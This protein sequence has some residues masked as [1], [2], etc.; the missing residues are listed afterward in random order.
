M[1]NEPVGGVVEADDVEP[2]VH[3]HTHTE[4]SL[5][6]G[7][8]RITDLVAA[9][10][11]HGQT[12]LAITDH[13]ALYG[14][15]KFYTAARSAGIKPIIGCEMYMAPR[16]R[17]DREGRT[18]RDPNH[19]I[20]LARNET[21]YR[22]L[23][24]LVSKSHLEGYYYKPRIDKELLAEHADGLICLSACIGGELPQAILGGDMDAAESVARQHME[25][26]GPDGYFLEMMDHA[27]AEE[28]A[29]RAGLLEIARRTG[30]PLVATNDAHYIGVEDA[31]AHDILLCIQTQARREDEKRFRFA[32]PH[33]SVTSGAHMRDRFAAYGEA[34]RNTVAV[35]GLCNLELKLG[36]NLL[37]AYSP[38]PQGHTAESY[39]RELCQ[40][41]LRERYGDGITAEAR[42]RLAME[43][44]VIETTGFAPY[45]LIVW[46]LIRAARCDGVVVGPGR[47]SSAGSLVA[48][49]LRITNICPLRYGLIFERFLNRER[50]EMPDID[51]DFDDRR[52]DR[53]LQYVQQKYGEDHVAQIITFGTMAARA[54][55]RDV[56]RALNVPLPDVDRLAK[57]V[58]LSVKITLEKA[59]ADSRELRGLYESE[60]WA[61]QVIDIA[62]RLEGI[63][64]N[65]ST[66]A[67]GVVIG[68]EPL[69][70]IVPLQ[71]STTGDRSSAVTMF[72]MASIS[73]VGL[74]KIDFLGLANLTVI[75][76]AV[77]MIEHSN[78]TG[79][80]IDMDE[81]PLDD[82]ATYALLCKADTHGIFQLESTFAKRILIDM[83]P[84]SLEDVGV[85]NALNR[86]GPIE[87][88]V[89]DLYSKRKRGEL[90][91]EYPAGLESL[92]EPVLA[93]T[94]GTM[95]YQDQVM[96]IAQAV[97]GFTLGEADLLRGAMGKKDKA[98]MAK[99]R[100]KFLA[101]AAL[102]GISEDGAIELFE[103]MAHFAGYGFNKAHAMAYGLIS[104]Q[105]AY[106]KA[107]HPVEYMAALLNSRGGDFD[108]LKQTIL[109]AHAH[110]LVVHKPDI[111]RSGEG[112][113]VG[114]RGIGEILFGLQHIKNVGESVT[115]A[116]VAARDEGGPFTSLLDLCM[117]VDSRDLNRRVLESLIQCG[118]LDSL[119]DRHA[120]LRQLDSSMDHA[121]AVRRERDLGQTAL[122]GDVVDIIGTIVPHA[123]MAAGEGGA[124]NGDGA[125][126]G[127]DS[128]LSWE[129]DL[130]GMYLSD[131]PLRRI[132]ATL[133]TRVDTSI[134]EL[135][136]HL[137]GLIVQVGG[138]IRDVR[139]FV[140]RKSTTGQR[141]AFL[142]IEDLTGSCEVVVFNRVFEEVAELLRPDAV[143]V[144]RGK[145]ESG[146]PSPNAAVD[147]EERES[148]PSK[149]RADAIFA[150][151]DARLVAWR[152]NSTVHIRLAPD[153]HHLVGPLHQAIAEH[154][155]DAPVVIHVESD[156]SIDDIALHEGF[157][158]EPGPGLERTVEALLGPGSYRLET[159]R[160]RAPER[161]TWGAARRT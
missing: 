46:D 97:A 145:V 93:E 33:F 114:D 89:V 9:A 7:A 81:I 147:D 115:H 37:P 149:I 27:I 158:V 80:R 152:R 8:S 91:V 129:R 84:R 41:G 106:L 101:G 22:N 16:S 126:K 142:Q 12:A 62:K 139:A 35:A 19:L 23:I 61:R 38:I 77:G 137:D 29:I 52:R 156:E 31:E 54:V 98:K 95:V 34:V 17:H 39:L 88:G 51:I 70:N 130:L 44:D 160:E 26:F 15:V 138:C 69:T 47:G 75:D 48:Y 57:L 53:V 63:C 151:D 120:L 108:K 133:Q 100:E 4:Y 45:F 161:E 30:L 144:I 86:P 49:V 42:E 159:R 36:G 128:W 87:G 6:D 55:I 82:P 134:N 116:I 154:R 107:N 32:G 50:V 109:D 85:A 124:G 136:A 121:A 73:Q 64:R 143:V 127:D 153:Q 74:L 43:L 96:K 60:G 79:T 59:L 155:G 24:Q 5:L 10:K 18:D 135:G 117:R 68:A 13:G 2:F 11:G 40:V 125:G 56:G 110:G 123:V 150:M 140:P 20:L 132:A 14:A 122:F 102:K 148:E 3:L 83:Q 119:G 113:T 28:E 76:E 146:R 71:R 66:H 65:A 105:T 25:M 1:V 111:N 72:D 78:S 90:S 141:M 112:F 103:L 21:G 67:A 58:P 94:H 92:L 157:T 99:Q 131:H 104:Y 118:A